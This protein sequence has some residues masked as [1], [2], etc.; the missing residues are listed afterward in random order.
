MQINR[1]Q[2]GAANADAKLK[3]EAIKQAEKDAEELAKINEKTLEDSL[4]GRQKEL[5]AAQ[6][7]YDE[8]VKKNKG[9]NEIL[10]ALQKQHYADVE[11][12]NEKFDAE[13]QKTK[14]EKAKRE[15]EEQQKKWADIDKAEEE[16][17]KDLLKL[18]DE[19]HKNRKKSD[20]QYLAD[21]YTLEVMLAKGNAA[22]IKTIDEQIAAEKK[23]L[24]K[25][26][27]KNTLDALQQTLDMVGEAA[28]KGTI[29]GKAA[30]IA[31]IGINTAK[32]IMAAWASSEE[33]GPILGPILAAVQTA[34]LLVLGGKQAAEVAKEK[35]PAKQK[36]DSGG[37]IGGTSMTGDQVPVMANSGE[38]MVNN[39]TMSNPQLASAI[40]N[41]NANPLGGVQGGNTLT[42]ERVV[43]L[44]GQSVKSIPVVNSEHF[45]TL[46]ANNVKYREGVFSVK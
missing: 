29:I 4:K 32:G 11:R 39:R 40:M 24:Q 12:I 8:E 22:K 18:N 1:R 37:F 10:L 9:K 6:F 38:F 33:L 20:S 7:A 15:F 23:K 3:A 36:L 43:Q 14:E 45:T 25:L 21:K 46:A 2:T 28:G 42:E 31:S 30:A 17:T 27:V 44:I 41:M 35:P 5:A 19:D 26:E 34:A 16:H 13:D